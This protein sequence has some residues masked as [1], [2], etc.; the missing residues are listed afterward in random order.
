VDLVVVLPLILQI[1][2]TE[3]QVKVLMVG[4]DLVVV[5]MQAAVVVLVQLALHHQQHQLVVDLVA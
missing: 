3:Y 1:Q 2:G 4:L 5:V